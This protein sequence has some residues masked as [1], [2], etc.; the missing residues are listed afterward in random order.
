M[1]KSR[2]YIATPPGATI[3]EQLENRGMS[4]KEFAKRMNM[5]EKHI[6]HLINGDVQLTP[7]VANRLE[8]VL[9]LPAKF[10]N[11]LESIYRDKLAKIEIEN[12]MDRDKEVIRSFPYAQMAKNNWVI[13]T[14]DKT[15][16]VFSLRKFFEVVDLSK[17]I[18]KNLVPQ[19]ACRRQASTEKADYAL[20]AWA[21]KAKMEARKQQVSPINLNRLNT[22]LPS[23]RLMTTKSPEIFCHS[24]VEE[25]SKCGISII[26]L[27]HIGGSFLHGAT[28]YDKN[29]IVVG[30]T[31][32]GKDADKFWFSLFHEFGHILLGHLNQSGTTDDDE[33]A[34]DEFAKNHLIRENDFESFVSKNDF[35]TNS[36]IEFSKQIDIA[37]GIVVGRLQKEGYI[38]FSWHN[39]LKERYSIIL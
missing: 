10:W 29:K 36:I 39:E 25:L 26:F 31:V 3:K 14:R 30:L 35:S 21:Q 38:N 2:S 27:P 6:S 15:E 9:G 17:M 37:P 22:L 1:T 34:A 23:I 7:D 32:R 12:S 28:F 16:R 4:Q 19:I 11:N 33:N 24:L 20:L 13:D 5:S 8:M 18:E